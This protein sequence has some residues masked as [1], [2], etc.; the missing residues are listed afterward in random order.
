[1]AS[2]FPHWPWPPSDVTLAHTQDG[3]GRTLPDLTDTLRTA[4]TYPPTYT[5]Q[6]NA[7]S[8]GGRCRCRMPDVVDKDAEAGG[9][10]SHSKLLI[11]TMCIG[12]PV[13]LTVLD[14]RW[15]TS[16]IRWGR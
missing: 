13:Q 1:M 16:V 7:C 3:R 10:C 9:K 14:V 6:R 4:Y 2:E 5:G 15:C 12:E 8:I 11:F